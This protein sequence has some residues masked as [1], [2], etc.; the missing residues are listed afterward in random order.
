MRINSDQQ[1]HK[2][3]CLNEGTK[4]NNKWMECLSNCH[5]TGALQWR[6]KFCVLKRQS[7][8]LPYRSPLSFIHSRCGGCSGCLPAIVITCERPLTDPAKQRKKKTTLSDALG[9]RNKNK[10]KTFDFEQTCLGCLYEHIPTWIKWMQKYAA[11]WFSS[12]FSHVATPK[13]ASEREKLNHTSRVKTRPAITCACV[14]L[15]SWRYQKVVLS[16][17]ALCT[18]HSS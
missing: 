15:H 11:C 7:F 9:L 4:A 18:L 17:S 1:P 10:K 5:L 14:C 8:A 6:G 13:K 12:R 2:Q 16:D 3:Q